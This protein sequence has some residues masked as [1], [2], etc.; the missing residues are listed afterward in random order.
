LQELQTSAQHD[1]VASIRGL[2]VLETLAGMRQPAALSAIAER[3]GLSQSQTYR[4]LDMLEQVDYVDHLGRSG[5]RLGPRSVALGALVGP[6]PV[7]V[8]AVQ[9]TLARLTRTTG[10]AAVLHLRTGDT[11]VLVLGLSAPAGSLHDPTAVLGERSPLDVGASG[12]VILAYLPESQLAAVGVRVDRPWLA[13]IRE[14]GYDISYGENH[15]NING[16]SGP[17]LTTDDHALG[18]ITVAGPADRLTEATIPR[19]AGPLL[20]ACRELSP[21]VAHLLGPDPGPVLESL[22]V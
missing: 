4:V 12:R 7:V 10:E 22:D 17:L 9:P 8:R 15:P 21:V 3:C 5:Y 6:R 20:A 2:L 14:R 1:R 19:L 11:R 13:R 18:S 16:V